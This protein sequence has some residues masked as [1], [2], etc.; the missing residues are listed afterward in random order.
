MSLGIDQGLYFGHTS[1]L[2]TIL[3]KMSLID[4]PNL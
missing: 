1:G 4:I 2:W 3:W